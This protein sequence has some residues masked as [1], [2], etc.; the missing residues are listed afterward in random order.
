MTTLTRTDTSVLTRWWWT[1]DRWNLAAVAILAA[2]GGVMALAASPPV[3]ERLDLPIFHFA[4]RQ[5]V[6]LG[7]GLPIMAAVSLLS[8]RGVRRLA[9]VLTGFSMLLM[10]AVLFVGPEI[11]GAARWLTL[12][13]LSFQPSEFVKPGLAVLAAWAF[14][15]G[16]I[17]PDFPGTLLSAGLFMAVAALLLLQPDVGMTIVA[18]GVWGVQLFLAGLPVIL[19]AGVAGVFL[20]GSAGVYLSF[21]HVRSRVDRFLDPEAAEGYQIMRSLDAFKN[22]GLTGRG[23]GEGRVKE[24]LP[25]A[26]TDFIFAVAGEEFGML[27]CVAIVAIFLF[28]ILRGFSKAM[29]GRSLFIMLA[30]AGLL[31]QIALQ[32]M[33]NLGSTL[34]LMPPKGMTLPFISYGGSS[35]LAVAIGLGMILALTRS[36]DDAGGRA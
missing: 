27:A 6:F 11:K 5:F 7:I 15:Q 4:S 3:A 2:I 19:V 14:A 9:L 16:K 20:I 13:G 25:D 10:F 8:P 17:D 26:H 36:R 1:I 34:H 30:T 33:I 28:I 22:G 29:K 35:T 21:A 18:A 24:V 32:A 31:V 12:G 23:P